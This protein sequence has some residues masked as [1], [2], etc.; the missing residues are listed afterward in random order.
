MN[1]ANQA[2]SIRDYFVPPVALKLTEAELTLREQVMNT[3]IATHQPYQA[4]NQAE[5]ELLQAMADKNTL[6][7]TNDQVTCIYP[8]SAIATNKKVIFADGSWVYAM[9]A[10]DAIGCH[11]TFGQE[12]I[13]E[14]VCEK[15]HE[16]L[17]LKVSNGQVTVLQGSDQ[18]YVLHADLQ[19][20]TNWSCSC[21]NIMHFFSC[22]DN[23]EQWLVEHQIKSKV[24]ALDLET[25]NKMAWL[26]FSK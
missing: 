6:A 11:Y 19:Q 17:V 24:F 2:I 16:P 9:C 26:L 4:R 14:S 10:I 1:Q 22:R 3:I 8:I 12:V 25:A 20:H 23:L 21:C 18:V 7:F 13:I 5:Q 15:C